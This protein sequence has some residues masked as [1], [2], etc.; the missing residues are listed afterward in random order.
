MVRIAHLLKLHFVVFSIAITTRIAF[1][2]EARGAC[3]IVPVS[4]QT[5]VLEAVSASAALGRAEAF[6]QS[7]AHG[8]E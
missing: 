7:G 1:A 8:G 3:C 2:A 4:A 5:V 6:F